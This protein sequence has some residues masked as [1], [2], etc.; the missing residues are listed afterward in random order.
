MTAILSSA[1]RQILVNRE[2]VLQTDDPNGAHQLRIG[3]RRLR[4]GLR[5]LRPLD[6][7]SL[8]AFERCA[9]D[10]GRCVGTL[11]D[12]DVLISGLHAPVEA[13]ASDKTGFAELRDALT[14]N[15]QAKRDEV[16]AALRGP[17]WTKPQ[18]YLSLWPR[19][20]AEDKRLEKPVLKH[21]RKVLAK[22]WKKCA[23]LG[24]RLDQLDAEQRHEMR[25]S[26]KNL[27]YQTESFAP[28]FS[29]PA[30]ECF[31]ERLKALQDVFGYMNDVRMAPRL[32]EVQKEQNAGVDAARAA[33]YAVGHHEAEAAHVWRAAGDAWRELTRTRRFWE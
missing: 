23:K 14:R 25:K 5:A 21:A 29:K 20:L 7:P 18:L 4:S 27:R 31:V 33:S 26:L 19:I 16:R 11:R 17:A 28:L 2:V 3:L 32:I 6:R 13:G 15:R 10:M 30:T 8:R 1:T 12:A 22:A 24:R 9:R